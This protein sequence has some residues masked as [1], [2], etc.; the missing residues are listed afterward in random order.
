[1]QET[2]DKKFKTKTI[3][4]IDISS[5]DLIFETPKETSLEK[6]GISS[7]QK[8]PIVTVINKEKTKLKTFITMEDFSTKQCLP[9]STIVPCFYCRRK[10][11]TVPIG[12]PIDFHPSVYVDKNDPKRIKK[13]TTKET[14]TLN[15]DS[16]VKLDYFDVDGIV[17]SFNCIFAFID[18]NPSH[19]YTKTPYL[20]PQMYKMIFGKF[21]SEQIFKSPSW[22]LRKEYGGVLSDEEFVK[23]LQTLKFTDTSQITKICRLNNPVGRVYKVEEITLT[24]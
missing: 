1:M 4:P 12:I 23:N 8:E 10:F 17:C 2:A 22:R 13:L 16:T 11:D 9:T 18:E 5:P 20:V 19:L 24:K 21:P 14:T 15:D 3:E 7:I 6:L